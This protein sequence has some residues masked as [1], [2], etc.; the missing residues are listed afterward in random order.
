MI[1][2]RN[3]SIEGAICWILHLIC[4]FS[5]S[6]GNALDCPQLSLKKH[7]AN[8]SLIEGRF[9]YHGTAMQGFTEIMN[10]R[11]MFPSNL[12]NGKRLSANKYNTANFICESSKKIV[13]FSCAQEKFYLISEGVKK[14]YL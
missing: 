5:L 11:R 13:I 7:L 1:T 14:L 6:Y 4:R 10:I 2:F 3:I 9:E 8:C 12:N